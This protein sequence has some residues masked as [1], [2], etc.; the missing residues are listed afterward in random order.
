ML[1][2]ASYHVKFVPN[3]FCIFLGELWNRYNIYRK[4]YITDKKT[5]QSQVLDSRDLMSYV[6]LTNLQREEKEQGSRFLEFFTLG[7]LN[8]SAYW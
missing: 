8:F 5:P 4:K 7:K 3:V 6:D 2:F 1:F